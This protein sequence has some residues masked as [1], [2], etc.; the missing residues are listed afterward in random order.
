VLGERGGVWDIGER[1]GEAEDI[2]VALKTV[3]LTEEGDTV[4]ATGE[5]DDTWL[6]E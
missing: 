6:A 4:E 5:G 1:G 3:G 2:I